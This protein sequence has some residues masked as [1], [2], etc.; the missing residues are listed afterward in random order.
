M[1]SPEIVALIENFWPGPLTLVVKK[2]C[3]RQNHRRPG[4]SCGEDAGQQAALELINFSGCP[5][6]APSA[7]LPKSQSHKSGRCYLGH[8]R[9]NRC[10]NHRRGLQSGIE[11]T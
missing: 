5:I 7:N 6:A 8:G 2:K 1:L 4:Y 10:R 3:S 9:K 11:S